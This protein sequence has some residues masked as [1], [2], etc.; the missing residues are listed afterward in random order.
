MRVIYFYVS[1]GACSP[2]NIIPWSDKIE[3]QNHYAKN[4]WTEG[5][6]KLLDNLAQKGIIDE[7]LVFI[8][9]TRN[10]GFYQITQKSKVYVVPH[11]SEA[12]NY[13]RPG[14]VIYA[15]GGFKPWIDTLQTLTNN[16]HWIM[17][18]RAN[19]NR[20]RWP[21]WD[22]I[23]DDLVDAN[24]NVGGR[25]GYAFRKPINEDLFYNK[26]SREKIYDVMVGASH[27][28][29]KK[30]QHLTIQGLLK[31]K[32]MFGKSLSIVLPGSFIKSYT[33]KS[34][35]DV[36]AS[37]ELVLN[38]TGMIDRRQLASTMN[39]TRL[40][41][42]LGPGGQNDRGVLEAM[43]CNT[44]AI[45]ASKRYSPFIYNNP[46][47]GKLITCQNDPRETATTIAETLTKIKNGGYKNVS[48]YYLK[49]NGMEQEAVPRMIKLLDFIKANPIPD[50]E[51][52]LKEFL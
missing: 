28:H 21:Y 9:S 22:I 3:T 30:G 50:R 4:I 18:Y 32:E 36:I 40:F 20:G 45:V 42:H 1:N 16:K 23:L 43:C 49:N 47:Y 46:E 19:T 14:D 5:P 48:E 27:I 52:L 6:F 12:L 7:Q 13:I 44:P 51:K 10:P 11:L 37:K 35:L 41:L 34:I 31:Y 24:Y 26:N 29:I 17:F 39:L 38:Y 2:D 25:L 33:N 8:D 15:R